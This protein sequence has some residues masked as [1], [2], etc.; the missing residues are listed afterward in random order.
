M[1]FCFNIVSHNYLF[2]SYLIILFNIITNHDLHDADYLNLILLAIIIADHN[3]DIYQFIIRPTPFLI[4]TRALENFGTKIFSTN[5]IFDLSNF[6]GTKTCHLIH[7]CHFIKILAFLLAK[8]VCFGVANR[9]FSN[10][11]CN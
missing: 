10:F 5:K 6:S 1:C 3:G 4:L 11:R 9:H 7:Y 8:G 2:Y